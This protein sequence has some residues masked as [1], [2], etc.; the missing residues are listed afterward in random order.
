MPMSIASHTGLGSTVR[1]HSGNNVTLNPNETSELAYA[2]MPK[3]ATCPSES[4]PA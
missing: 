4:C 2:P 1:T 3:N